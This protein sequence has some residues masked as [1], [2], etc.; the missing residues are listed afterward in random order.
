MRLEWKWIVMIMLLAVMPEAG[1]ARDYSLQGLDKALSGDFILRKSQ[2]LDSLGRRARGRKDAATFRELAGEYSNFNLDSALYYNSLARKAAA[3]R[4]EEGRAL[5]QL[6]GLYNSSLLMYKEAS[7]IFGNL[8]PDMADETFRKDYF[9][10]GVQMYRNLER[11][12]PEDS[13]RR[14]YGRIKQAFRD[15]VMLL[16]PDERFI[17]ANEL[18]DAGQP[19]GV[20]KLFEKELSDD[21]YSSSSGAVYHLISRAYERLGDRDKEMDYLAKAAQADIENGVREYLALPQLALRLYEDG[22]VTRAY[23][24]MQRSIED[25]KEC[26]ARV[27]LFDMAE[28]V[29]AISDAYA[30]R[31]RSASRKLWL[32]LILV[33]VMLGI[34]GVA[35]YY[36]RQRNR[37]LS[38]ART[39]LE[40]GNRRLEAAG[41]VREKYVRRF[42]NLSREYLEELDNYRTRLFKIGAKRNFDALFSAIKSSEIIDTTTSTF[43]TSFDKAFLELYPDFIEEFNSYLR[44]EERIE[45]NDPLSLNTELRIFALMKLGVTESAEIARFLHCSQS[46]VYNYRTRYRS[47]AIDREAFVSHF[48]TG[49]GTTSEVADGGR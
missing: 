39:E 19:A 5:L 13:M 35:L 48:F 26:G 34:V 20:L 31:Q 45:L 8:K 46:T 23:Q 15:S 24:Y 28:T 11:L 43:F 6:A 22:D 29:S 18:L 33:G 14:H 27:R 12:A 7:E 30:A 10:L 17:R 36:A 16:A 9:V 25:A 21:K 49:V 42:I 37:L 41:N 4:E 44:P 38:Q 2:R 3:D 47:R 1:E 40:E 32:M